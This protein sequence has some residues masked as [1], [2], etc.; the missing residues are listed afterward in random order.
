MQQKDHECSTKQYTIIQNSKK[1][2]CPAKINLQEVAEFPTFK[3]S[4][5][6]NRDAKT[7][8]FKHGEVEATELRPI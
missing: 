5:S 1:F 3:V 6:F 4:L 2:D 7:I 8:I